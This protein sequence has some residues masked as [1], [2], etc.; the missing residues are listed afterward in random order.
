MI[1]RSGRG[2]KV[3]VGQI[4]PVGYKTFQYTPVDTLEKN[5]SKNI[6][7]ET[8]TKVVLENRWVAIQINRKSGAIISLYDKK[9]N[10]EWIDSQSGIGFGEY[11]YDIYGKE[12]L[13]RFMKDY[14]Y[15]LTDWYVNDFG[16]AGYPCIQGQT[17]YATLGNI[18]IENGWDWG[19]VVITQH[20]H[21]ESYEKY[22]NAQTI[23]MRITLK[24][25]QK[26]ADICYTLHEKQE[27]PFLEAGHFVFPLKTQ[28]P[29][30]RLEKMGSVINPL[31]DIQ[32]KANTRLHSCDQWIDVQDG[33]LGI[34]F[35]PIDSP[36]VSI[37]EQGV[38]Q[39]ADSYDPQQS[40]LYF[41]VFNNQWG[42]NF[43]QWMGGTYAFEFR[44]A[45]HEGSWHEGG[46]WKSAAETRYPLTAIP[47]EP[48]QTMNN[49][50]SLFKKDLRGMKVLAFKPSDIRDG[51]YILRM[52][53]LLGESRTIALSFQNKF[54]EV[55][56]CDLV[57]REMEKLQLDGESTVAMPIKPF[58]ILTLKL[59][60]L[61]PSHWGNGFQCVI[62]Q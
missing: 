16:K 53:D 19:R 30:Y 59:V 50:F 39:Y 35:I 23:C 37:G 40:T 22:G 5:E 4:P 17:Y 44:I 62:S 13:L 33:K 55:I 15:D 24:E 51:S 11:L 21:P 25:D 49:V 58:E 18:S 52:Q 42:T 6:A 36:L 60:P 34:G 56:V 45:L 29:Q 28:C 8:E 38:L 54:G 9:G 46:I 47:M 27:T 61:S 10:K 57:E 32:P 48:E 7:I 12:D 26:G 41:N 2:G 3:T 14:A 43:P 20:T 1:E 31:T